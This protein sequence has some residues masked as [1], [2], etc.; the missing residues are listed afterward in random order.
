MIN[1]PPYPLAWPDTQKRTATKAKSAFRTGLTGAMDNVSKSLRAFAQDS[2]KRLEYC[3]I[4]S[5]AGLFD[6]KPA[7]PGIAVW[8][9]WDGALRCIA[10]DR[11]QTVAENLQAIHHVLEARRVEL[12]HAGIEMVRTTFRGFVAALPAPDAKSWSDILGVPKNA[13]AD[14][15]SAAYKARARD[16]AQRGDQEQLVELNVA[17]DRAMAGAA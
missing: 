12:R 16:L 6:Q 10:V 15:I 7:D 3:Q 17:R 4:T 1:I 13:T 9:E 14:Q 2:E 11:Y 8:F 5:N